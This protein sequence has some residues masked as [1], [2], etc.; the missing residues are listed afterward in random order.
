MELYGRVVDDKLLVRRIT[1]TANK[2][3]DES[4]VKPE[5]EYQ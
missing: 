5:E 3:V 4:E 1:I 2:L